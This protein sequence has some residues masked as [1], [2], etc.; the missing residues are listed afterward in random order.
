MHRLH[1]TKSMAE[2]KF[3]HVN[4]VEENEIDIWSGKRR[5]HIRCKLQSMVCEWF[6]ANISRFSHFSERG[7]RD[8]KRFPSRA[9]YL[10]C[11]SEKWQQSKRQNHKYEWVHWVHGSWFVYAV[12]KRENIESYA[13]HPTSR[14]DVI[15]IFEYEEHFSKHTAS[16]LP[17]TQW[18]CL[19]LLMNFSVPVSARILRGDNDRKMYR[20]IWVLSGGAKW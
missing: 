6:T 14:I 20:R 1:Y 16:A 17:F 8:D 11:E 12:R 7:P 4:V 18:T 2:R 15:W 19:M 13:E 10:E 3:T 9:A 5:T